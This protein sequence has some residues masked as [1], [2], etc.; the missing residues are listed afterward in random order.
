METMRKKGKNREIKFESLEK[1]KF[2]EL[3]FVRK[4]KFCKNVKEYEVNKVGQ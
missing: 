1:I 4:T 3:K 2:L